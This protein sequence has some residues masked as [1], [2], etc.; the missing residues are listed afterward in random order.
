MKR[1]FVQGQWSPDGVRVVRSCTGGCQQG[2]ARCDCELA[3]DVA[4]DPDRTFAPAETDR[5]LRAGVFFFALVA[6]LALIAFGVGL[7]WGAR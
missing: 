7:L 3:N 4:P 2:R 1:A 6:S 5:E